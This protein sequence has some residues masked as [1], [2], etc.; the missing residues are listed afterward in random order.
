ML[1]LAIE[2]SVEVFGAL[3]AHQ[4]VI[5]DSARIICVAERLPQEVVAFGKRDGVLLNV[6]ESSCWRYILASMARKN[7]RSCC[8]I[9]Y[10]DV[11]I[12]FHVILVDTLKEI[13]CRARLH[14]YSCSSRHACIKEVAV[15]AFTKRTCPIVSH[16][17]S[18]FARHQLNRYRFSQMKRLFILVKQREV[19]P[20]QYEFIRS[21]LN[22]N[23]WRIKDSKLRFHT[24][25]WAPFESFVLLNE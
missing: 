25:C 23:P 17:F 24:D 18:R 11:F 12:I 2:V 5:A 1:T 19:D 6:L 21:C 10:F 8:R 3:F 4:S 22:V 9:V 14:R 16:D 7:L 20:H 13:A 15:R